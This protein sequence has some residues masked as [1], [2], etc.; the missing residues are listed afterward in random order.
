[1]ML[2]TQD[3]TNC[4]EMKGCF[5]S[6]VER[7]TITPCPGHTHTFLFWKTFQFWFWYCFVYCAAWSDR[8]VWG[9]Q[10]V[11]LI[12]FNLSDNLSWITLNKDQLHQS[13]HSSY[14]FI[15]LSQLQLTITLITFTQ[16]VMFLCECVFVLLVCQQ[17]K[18]WNLEWGVTSGSDPG[19][20]EWQ[21][22]HSLTSQ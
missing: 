1:M 22:S 2:N 20:R 12:I 8:D 13:A 19:W 9:E 16:T 18:L 5:F 21:F 4:N 7:S 15:F 3:F 11:Q 10:Q 6:F 17:E 14:W